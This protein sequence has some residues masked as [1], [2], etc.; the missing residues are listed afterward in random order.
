MFD[1][2]EDALLSA[3]L[4]ERVVFPS[5]FRE[6][7]VRFSLSDEKE[8]PGDMVLASFGGRLSISLSSSGVACFLEGFILKTDREYSKDDERPTRVHV[9]VKLTA[10]PGCVKESLANRVELR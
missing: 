3:P 6:A 1:A 4:I 7:L 5:V 8:V 10:R 2:I 9:D